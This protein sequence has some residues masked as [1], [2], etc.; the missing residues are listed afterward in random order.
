MNDEVILLMK[1]HTV[2]MIGANKLLTKSEGAEIALLQIGTDTPIY[3]AINVN[4]LPSEYTPCSVRYTMC[5]MNT[6]SLSDCAEIIYRFSDGLDEE[7]LV[8]APEARYVTLRC[9]NFVDYLRFIVSACKIN[10]ARE[11]ITKYRT[12]GAEDSVPFIALTDVEIDVD[13]DRKLFCGNDFLA[14]CSKAQGWNKKCI[15]NIVESWYE[16]KTNSYMKMAVNY[17]NHTWRYIKP[18]Y[19]NEIHK[20]GISIDKDEVIGIYCYSAF[21]YVFMGYDEWKTLNLIRQADLQI[22][23]YIPKDDEDSYETDHPITVNDVD[24]HPEY[25]FVTD[26]YRYWIKSGIELIN[27]LASINSLMNT[28]RVIHDIAGGASSDYSAMIT[29]TFVMYTNKTVDAFEKAITDDNEFS[30]YIDDWYERLE[31]IKEVNRNH[32]HYNGT[33]C[34][35]SITVLNDERVYDEKC[36]NISM[37]CKNIKRYVK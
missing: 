25:F 33:F 4:E 24:N 13:D 26:M 28:I 30:D 12:M 3:L 27:Y 15:T 19:D 9:K 20:T 21:G 29:A 18:K 35:Y 34:D 1:D 36:D 22:A 6:Q 32:M 2:K 31:G 16:K 11:F 23:A 5:V 37:C 7:K 10:E 17:S 14:F 8:N